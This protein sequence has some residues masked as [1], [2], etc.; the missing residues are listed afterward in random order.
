M[1]VDYGAPAVSKPTNP[2]ENR[3]TDFIAYFYAQAERA[4]GS[5]RK[6]NEFTPHRFDRPYFQM[7]GSAHRR[8]W[9]LP[10]H[11]LGLRSTVGHRLD[12]GGRVLEAA[13]NSPSTIASTIAD[14]PSGGTAA[15]SGPLVR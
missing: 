12:L 8:T 1:K 15:H 14:S 4:Q 6:G 11:G 5:K 10:L 2:T 7:A 9:P 3:K 13:G